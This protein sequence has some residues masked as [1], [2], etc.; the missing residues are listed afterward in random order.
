M[1][2][3]ENIFARLGILIHLNIYIFDQ[4]NL[5]G[6]VKLLRD[7]PVQVQLLQALSW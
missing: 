4:C 2:I 7:V 3:V 6:M 5:G 1:L